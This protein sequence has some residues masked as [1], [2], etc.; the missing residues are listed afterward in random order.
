M[1]AEQFTALHKRL[2][3]SRTAF[4]R[5]L[6]IARNSANAYAHGRPIPKHIALAC[7]A[8]ALCLAPYGGKDNG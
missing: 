7:T 2:G 8:V 4:A 1:T 6:G 5:E 3:L